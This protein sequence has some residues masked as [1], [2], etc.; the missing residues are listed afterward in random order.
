MFAQY[1]AIVAVILLAGA[2]WLGWEWRDRSAD[3]QI[4]KIERD[5][6]RAA[7]KANEEQARAIA[8]AVAK[9]PRS[10]PKIREVV[11]ANPSTCVR[12]A[13]VADSLQAAVRE[14]NAARAVSA[15]R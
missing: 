6:A 15:H 4:A 12:P 11:R 1:K 14:A 9:V 5:A 7:I 8:E 3:A 13:A 2:T 10:E